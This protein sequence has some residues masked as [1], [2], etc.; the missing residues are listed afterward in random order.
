M[1]RI[2][3]RSD[4]RVS[5]HGVLLQSGHRHGLLLPQVATERNWGAEQF[6]L[7]LARKAGLTRACTTIQ[8][9]SCMFSARRSSTNSGLPY[10]E[11]VMPPSDRSYRLWKDAPCA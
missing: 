5:V 9:P 11:L 7:A 8:P 10:T 4:F 2:V 3:D 1:K 6:F